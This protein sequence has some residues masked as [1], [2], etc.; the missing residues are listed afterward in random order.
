MGNA[1][2]LPNGNTLITESSFGRFFEVTKEGE[3][4]WEYINPFFGKPFFA[5]RRSISTWLSK[6]KSPR[7]RRQKRQ[8]VA[9]GQHG[10]ARDSHE[11]FRGAHGERQ[12][13]LHHRFETAVRQ[14]VLGF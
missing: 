6:S 10:I 8:V 7:T 5:S 9:F 12:V 11:P 13:Q 2:C 14:R 1:Q 4:V 3:I